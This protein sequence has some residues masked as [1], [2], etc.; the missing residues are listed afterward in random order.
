MSVRVCMCVCVS[1]LRMTEHAELFVRSLTAY[2]KV[3]Q[4]DICKSEPE[5][6][7]RECSATLG[8]QSAIL[9]AAD[10]KVCVALQLSTYT[11]IY[12]TR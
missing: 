4:S 10:L 11:C 6:T 9:P 1:Q 5:R 12:F 2:S 8:V 7:L 3:Q